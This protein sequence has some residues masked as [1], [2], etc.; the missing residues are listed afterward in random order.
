MKNF[1]KIGAPVALVIAIAV[2]SLS[3]IFLGPDSAI[4]ELSE[5]VVSTIL[6]SG[7]DIDFSPGSPEEKKM[8]DDLQKMIV[9]KVYESQ[10]LLTSDYVIHKAI[11]LAE[12]KLSEEQFDQKS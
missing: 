12:E 5:N 3:S 10:S 4:E 2:G 7:V 11:K 1:L 8:H 6:G 9:E